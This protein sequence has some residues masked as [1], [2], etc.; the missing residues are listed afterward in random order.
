MSN[1]QGDMETRPF[2]MS[3]KSLILSLLIDSYQKEP[4]L[5]DYFHGSWESL[6]KSKFKRRELAKRNGFLSIVNDKA[7]G[8]IAWDAETMPG[9]IKICHNCIIESAK[10]LGL[11]RNQ[12]RLAMGQILELRPKA[13][14]ANTGTIDFFE[15]ARRM[16]ESFGFR[17]AGI[18]AGGG[19]PMPAIIQYEY[20][21]FR[22]GGNS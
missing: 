2:R 1:E 8:F 9:I 10:G 13:I 7:I 6:V 19:S 12:L 4:E 22:A 18:V 20:E 11:G 21:I 15:P 5:I 17:K 14:I 16:Y 3:D